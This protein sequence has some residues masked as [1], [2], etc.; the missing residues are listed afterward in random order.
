M[1]KANY[2]KGLLC[3]VML[4][5]FS[6]NVFAQEE[7]LKEA[8]TAYTKEDYTKAIELY[9]NVVKTYGSSAAVYY[10]LGNAYYKAGKVGPAILNYERCLLLKPSDA[11]ARFNLQ[12]AR[13][14]AVDKIDPVGEFFLTH[15]FHLLQN[16][17]SADT[18]AYWGVISFLLYIGCLAFFFFSKW[19]RLKKAGFYLGL[20]MLVITVVSNVFAKKQKDKLV[21][22]NDAIVFA[23]TVTVKSSPDASGT[24]LFILHEG[25]K[26]KIKSKLGNWSEIMVEDGN[27][28]W[29][30]NE[31]FEV[32]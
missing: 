2:I 14:K 4:Q 5:L 28:G 18:W 29:M 20:V 22:R 32:I 16:R 13:Q 26:V 6:W 31:N 7:A 3:V 8:E 9:E 23:P 25:T 21:D 10:N 24:D 27:V 30:A 17:A 15:W 19:L 1:M 12:L 11:D